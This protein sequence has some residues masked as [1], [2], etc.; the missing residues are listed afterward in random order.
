MAQRLNKN[1]PEPLLTRGPNIK[2]QD[3]DL[4]PKTGK[5]SGSIFQKMFVASVSGSPV[6][7]S[8]FQSVVST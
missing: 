7:R 4:C 1:V 6:R 8:H 2:D 5:E 3:L